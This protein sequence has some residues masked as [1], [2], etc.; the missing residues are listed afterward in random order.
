[1]KNSNHGPCVRIPAS[2]LLEIIPKLK[3]QCHFFGVNVSLL[4]KLNS[5]LSFT[6]IS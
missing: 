4:S 2:G 6:P 5:D 3:K 1:M